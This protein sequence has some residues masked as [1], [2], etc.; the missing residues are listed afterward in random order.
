[1]EDQNGG[2]VGG[3]RLVDC[4][5]S[6][7]D[8]NRNVNRILDKVVLERE[9]DNT[10]LHKVDKQIIV[11]YNVYAPNHFKGKERCWDDLKTNIDAEES[12][13]IAFGGD[14]NII[15]HS[16]QKLGGSFSP[17][18]YI[19]HLENLMQDHDL[20]NVAPKNRRY[21]WRNRKLGKGNIMERLDKILIN[22]TFLSSF[23]AGYATIL[24]F[25]SSDHYPITLTLE[26]H[27]SLGPIPFK[28][29]SLW[30][31]IPTV[32]EIVQNT[33]C[34]HV[35]GSP[36]YIW[37]TKLRKTKQTLKEW[38][39]IFYKESKKNKKEIKSKLDCIP[40]IIEEHNLSQESKDQESDLYLQP[41][42]ANR[43]EELKW[44]IKSRQLWLQRG[45]KNSTFF[46]KHTTI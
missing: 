45:D 15:L 2:Y 32:K 46:H 33:W 9:E 10:P 20:I 21:T 28:Y 26:T 6:K 37:E 18:P 30:N 11:I 16:F 41:C 38:G 14:F 1:M 25:S 12:Y 3:K 44:R 39:K 4:R 24:P 36:G 27:C 42:R 22:V 23:S 17:D 43:E 19:A 40:R 13:N 35:E 5:I 7:Y 31:F 8:T 29:S 34:Q